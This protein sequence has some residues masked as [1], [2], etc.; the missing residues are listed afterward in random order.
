MSS[1]NSQCEKFVPMLDA[2][3]DNELEGSE[4]EQVVLHLAAC[5]D[6]T[7]QVKE[8]EALKVSL[9][10]L[11]R[12][13]MKF[14]LADNFDEVLSRSSSA[15]SEPPSNVVPLRSKRKWLVASA[16]AA[17]AVVIAIAGSIVLKGDPQQV[18]HSNV[19]EQSKMMAVKSA[20]SPVQN[21]SE[22]SSAQSAVD[23]HSKE[24]LAQTQQQERIAA[25]RP[26]SNTNS[27]AA[28][29]TAG[30][31][32]SEE[33]ERLAHGEST[34]AV[35]PNSESTEPLVA[36]QSTKT[37]VPASQAIQSNRAAS[38]ELLALYEDDDGISSD[39]GV[40][41]DEDGLYAIKL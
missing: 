7:R 4:K 22:S 32:L 5:D 34:T 38:S 6:C 28:N 23:T 16:T 36:Q 24:D 17:A 9:S 21:D 27:P 14:D 18:A 11:P 35:A 2:F 40:S 33:T 3:V 10:S 39:I 12:R 8:I 20:G 13:Q 26:Q 1:K 37:V 25:H 31:H 15:Q 41:T 19:D 29:K 30:A